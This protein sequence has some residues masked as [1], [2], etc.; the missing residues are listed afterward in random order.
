MGRLISA[1]MPTT[2][3]PGWFGAGRPEGDLRE[4]VAC[5]N[6]ILHIPSR[7]LLPHSPRYWS[8]NALD[9]AYDPDARAPRFEKFL[10]EIWPEDAEAQQCLLEMFGLCITDVTKYQKAFMFVGPRRGGRG[11]I[12]RVRMECDHSFLTIKPIAALLTKDPEQ[13]IRRELRR[14]K[15]LME[16]GE[17]ITTKGQPSG[18]EGSLH[19]YRM[20]V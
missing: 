10:G 4:L 18:R 5:A 6:G 1:L 20:A 7:T 3:M 9:F 15:Q 12:V 8:P 19:R 17:I 2:A 14:F 13:M 11:T 16:T